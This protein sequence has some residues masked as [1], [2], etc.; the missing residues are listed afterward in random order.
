VLSVRSRNGGDF[1]V[2]SAGSAA[3]APLPTVQTYNPGGIATAGGFQSFTVDVRNPYGLGVGV[4]GIDGSGGS[5]TDPGFVLFDP[6]GR[7]LIR[8]DDSGVGRDAYGQAAV[9]AG[10]HTAVVRSVDG[11][12]GSFEIF[13]RADF[14]LDRLRHPITLGKAGRPDFLLLGLPGVPLPLVP[15]FFQGVLLLDPVILLT[16][17]QR[18]I[19]ADG[20]AVYGFALPDPFGLS[21]QRVSFEPGPNFPCR[22]GERIDV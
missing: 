13:V 22:L 9:V 15:G 2:S 18:V 5:L 14:H 21:I 12:T 3:P 6:T 17:S 11:N 16:L 10:A 1:V 19:A 8:D 7:V 4:S 20:R